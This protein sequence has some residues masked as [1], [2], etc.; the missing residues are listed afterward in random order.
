MLTSFSP[1]SEHNIK[2]LVKALGHRSYGL[3]FLSGLDLVTLVD[4]LL[5]LRLDF[6][7][8]SFASN[9][10][11]FSISLSFDSMAA[12]WDSLGAIC[13]GCGFCEE[14]PRLLA[15]LTTSFRWL[16]VNRW[17]EAMALS[18]DCFSVNVMKQYPLGFPISYREAGLQ[19][20]DQ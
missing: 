12:I 13:T 1:I 7:S 4:C 5:R 10:D 3:T 11:S 14:E 17:R 6:V 19:C 9:G 8:F 20:T 18:A 15:C 2:S 16:S